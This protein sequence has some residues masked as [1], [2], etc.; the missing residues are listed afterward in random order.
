M[1]NIIFGSI[2][3]I[4]LLSACNMDKDPIGLLTPDQ[5]ED[6]PT[7]ATLLSAV[8][9]AYE[10]LRNTT[11]FL[12]DGGWTRGLYIRPDF[13]LEDIAGGDMNKKWV[14]DGDQAWMDEFSR[15]TFTAD[16]PGFNGLWTYCYEGISRANLAIGKLADPETIQE[17]GIASALAQRLLAE[18]LFLR[19]YYYF[20]LVRNFGD[21]PLVVNPLES[22]DDAYNVSIKVPASEVWQ[23]IDMDLQEAQSL[24]V[25]GK[26]PDSDNPWRVSK[27][28]ILALKAKVAL[29]NKD[30]QTVLTEINALENL[31][32]YHLNDNYFDSFRN[33]KEYQ[34]DEV[35]FSYNH[36]QG[37][38]P[39]NGNGIGSLLGWGFLAP[40]TDFINEFEENDPRLAYTVDT[41]KQLVYKLMGALDASN[42]G[43]GDSPTNKILIR[44]ADVLLWKAEAS[45]ETGKY[46]EAVNLINQI[47]NRARNT[48]TISGDQAPSGTLPDRDPSIQNEQQ[49]RDWLIHERR[50]ELGF[51]QHRFSD[52]RR[53][54][55]AEET[56]KAMGVAFQSIHYLYPIPQREIDL[57][58]GLITQN[59]DYQ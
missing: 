43:N 47:R 6:N 41:D 39:R 55:I 8:N 30:W 58:G 59:E 19:S 16:N 40:T 32:Y 37:T 45:L 23:Q 18:A 29:F 36:T 7:E 56:L 24:M 1:K 11:A 34:E 20:E 53:W 52:L 35:V 4:V 48:V 21:I 3:T 22:F 26:Y 31:G 54:G 44:W 57:S 10:P 46:T 12:G 42:R 25:D 5:V 49:I 51:E 14:S 9:S 2:F 50:V 38:I 15:F 27:G 28:A 13:V 17:A 33:S